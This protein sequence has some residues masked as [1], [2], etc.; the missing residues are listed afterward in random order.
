[1]HP[2]PRSPLTFA[3]LGVAAGAIPLGLLHGFTV[4]DALI[5]ARYAHHLALGLGYRFNVGGPVTDGVTPL[6]WAHLLAPFAANGPR[7]AR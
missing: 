7:A 3:A 4:D 2:S 6:G 5:P 1:M